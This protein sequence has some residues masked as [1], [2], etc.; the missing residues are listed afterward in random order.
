[1]TLSSSLKLGAMILALAVVSGQG[2]AQEPGSQPAMTAAR[3][4]A[5]QGLTTHV[6]KDGKLYWIEGGGG[7]SGVIIGD[8][9]VVVIDAK[10]T[11]AS[12]AQL[13]AE[14]AKLTPK[15]ITH[16]ILTH[17]DGDHVN[18]L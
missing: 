13:V 15:P 7:N 16:V 8:K 17:S 6:I 3:A 14:I 1:M 9:G 2:D 12:G 11:D 18:G 4:Q 10:T 5:P